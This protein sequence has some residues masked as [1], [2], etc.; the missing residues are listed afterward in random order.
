MYS[1]HYLF[2]LIAAYFLFLRRSHYDYDPELIF[3]LE[4]RFDFVTPSNRASSATG[5]IA[6]AVPTR[7][8]RTSTGVEHSSS[9]SWSNSSASWSLA[10]SPA[11][12]SASSSAAPRSRC[13]WGLPTRRSRHSIRRPFMWRPRRILRSDR[14]RHSGTPALRRPS[15]YDRSPNRSPGATRLEMRKSGSSSSRVATACLASA[16]R[17]R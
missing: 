17:S 10:W 15:I 11:A 1:S 16:S 7:F 12:R 14:P 3:S 8:P 5:V 6:K 13:W 9:S 4:G 2:L